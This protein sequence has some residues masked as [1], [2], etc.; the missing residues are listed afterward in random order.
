M[1]SSVSPLER[2]L[3]NLYVLVLFRTLT[4]EHNFFDTYFTISQVVRASL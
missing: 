2:L 3:T 1:V 4:K